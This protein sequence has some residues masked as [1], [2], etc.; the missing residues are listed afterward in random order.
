MEQP[1]E[2]VDTLSSDIA[3]VKELWGSSQNTWRTSN[4]VHWTQLNSVQER[5][6]LLSANLNDT[7][8][9]E[10]ALSGSEILNPEEI[11]LGISIGTGVPSELRENNFVPREFIEALKAITA[12]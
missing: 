3:K 4:I 5:M 2:P 11:G 6:N 10:L 9:S 7:C 8:L 1:V 12:R